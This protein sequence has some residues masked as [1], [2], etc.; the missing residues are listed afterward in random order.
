MADGRT[1]LIGLVGA[2][3]ATLLVS[4]VAL[5]EGKSNDPYQDIVGV[6]TVCY[7]ETNVPMRRYSDQECEAMLADSL[8]SYAAPVLAVNPE[9]RG[10]PN[11]IAAATSLAYNIGITNYRRSTVARRFTAGDWKG[12]CDAFLMWNR[13]GGKVRKGLTNRR[14]YERK[15]CLRGL[16]PSAV[17]SISDAM[18]PERFR[19]PATASAFFV[20][21]AEVAGRCNLTAPPGYRIFACANGRDGAGVMVLTDPT[22][23]AL[24]GEFYARI[25]A[26]EIAHLHGWNHER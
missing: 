26:H 9:L 12:A 6:W 22:P 24:E 7:G 23:Y 2:S 18:P 21:P 1:R 20:P 8:A 19:G 15:I 16:P 5:W 25:V 10:H 11:Q 3:A 14:E 17:T 13:A 4:T